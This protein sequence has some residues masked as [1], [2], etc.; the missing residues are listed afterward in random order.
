MA[1]YG[2]YK[3]GVIET[4]FHFKENERIKLVPERDKKKLSHDEM[5][6]L[7]DNLRGSVPDQCHLL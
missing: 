2:T 7:I 3:N 5:I 4:E 6:S 1:M